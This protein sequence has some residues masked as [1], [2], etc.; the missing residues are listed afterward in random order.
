MPRGVYTRTKEQKDKISK[1]LLLKLTDEERKTNRNASIKK[2]EETHKEQ[3]KLYREEHKEQKR[4]NDKK[5][6]EEHIVEAKAYRKKYQKEHWEETSKQRKEY[7]QTHKKEK[8]IIDRASYIRNSEQRKAYSK[9]FRKENNEK[10]KNKDKQYRLTPSGKIARIKSYVKRK[11][12]LG[13]DNL[14][15]WFKDSN[16]H[17]ITHNYVIFIPISLHIKYSG[18][19][20]KNLES[21]I[22][23]NIEAFKYLN[24][25][26]YSHLIESWTLN[27]LK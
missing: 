14:N 11:K 2:Y 15:D 25:N 18:H 9:K 4:I 3:K 26:V 8:Q 20:L 22:K 6:Y 21:M 10:C 19:A 27:E 1:T 12:D 16:A 13:F 5:Y 7:R 23:I 24:E 17:H